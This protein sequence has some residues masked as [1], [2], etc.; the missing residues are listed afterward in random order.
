[1]KLA[2]LTDLHLNFLNKTQRKKFIDTVRSSETDAV[3]IGG[4]IGESNT[5]IEY[6]R[7]FEQHLNQDIY[8][9]LGNNDYYRGSI[10]QV[11][12]DISNISNNS[13]KLNWLPNIGIKELTSKTALIGH[14]AWADGR[15]GDFINSD[16]VLND[17]IWIKEFNPSLFMLSDGKDIKSSHP[18]S[19]VSIE[20]H[21]KIG[22]LK[23][24]NRLGDEAAQHVQKFLLKALEFYDRVIFLTHVPPFKESC[25]YRKSYSEAEALPHYSCKAVGDVIVQ[26]MEQHS[27]KHLTVLCGHTHT[28]C[29]LSVLPNLLVLTGA[30]Q[31]SN[32]EIQKVFEIS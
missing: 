31:Y 23:T 20:P 32:P 1:M 28:K 30:A 26:I 13:K 5:L 7:E 15:L 6:L 11:R 18:T 19:S 3:L 8:F 22:R 16:L 4:D 10:E 2:W 12:L 25:L 24:M 21:V 17:Y 9:I 29:E 14:G 27:E